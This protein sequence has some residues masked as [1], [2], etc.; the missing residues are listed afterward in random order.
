[1]SN[2]DLLERAERHLSSLCSVEPNRRTGSRGNQQATDYFARVVRSLGYEP[3]TTPF[4]CLDWSHGRC[5]LNDGDSGFE[6]EA[7]PY[8]LGCN[9][10]S[11]VVTAA[12]V[13]ELTEL[14][15]SGRILLLTGELSSEQL[16]PKNF[17]FYNPEHHG[18]L[19]A[20]LESK[21]PGAIIA[22][23]RHN[24]G[25]AGAL[26]PFPLIVDGDFHIPCAHCTEVIGEKI[27]SDPARSF[28]L[29]IDAER[30]PSSASNVICR[31]N[32]HASQKIL[33]T[34]H[35]DAYEDTPGATDNAAGTVVLLL[36][37][38]LLASRE[39][40]SMTSGRS[41]RT[42]SGSDN[43]ATYAAEPP[44]PF[45]VEIV[46]F[47]GEDHY[48]AAGQLDYLERYGESL[49]ETRFV[50]NID[51]AGFREG[52]TA[53]SFY[54]LPGEVTQSAATIFGNYPEIIEG[55]QWFAGDHS[56]FLQR[57]VPAIAV[58]T[59]HVE[60]LVERIAHTPKDSPE[61]VDCTKLVELA[62]AL[63]HFLRETG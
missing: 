62:E 33:I 61:L 51:G 1:M 5:T 57:G 55:P 25:S 38:E 4:P 42:Y 56:V 31:L 59:E 10:V 8:S 35:I 29:I 53:Y 17:P 19:Y 50:I 43:R 15:C 11:S 2:D 28:H 13:E 24:P 9:L 40:G 12:T 63:V 7:S 30:H 58:T 46:A 21:Q 45:G 34:A 22:A 39:S 32:P 3:E 47:N 16:M 20:L 49:A 14:E 36:V 26:Y 48:S 27:A 23:T 37:A 52:A 54:D 44:P 41:A 60:Q 6:L 18:Q